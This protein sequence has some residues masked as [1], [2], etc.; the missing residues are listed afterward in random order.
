MNVLDL[1]YAALMALRNAAYDRGLFSSYRSALPV[2][3]VGN[4]SVGGNGKTPLVLYLAGYLKK[5]GKGPVILSRGYG[6][7]CL[8]PQLVTVRDSAMNVGDEPWMMYRK[9]ICPVVIARQRAAGAS[10]I[11]ENRIGETILLDD[12]FQ[13][14]ALRRNLD[15]VCAYAGST[16]AIARF[17]CDRLLPF[18]RLREQKGPA[19]ERAQAIMFT[20]R[21][22]KRISAEVLRDLTRD[23]PRHLKVFSSYLN[24]QRI[25]NS[26]GK[27]LSST[28]TTQVDAFCALAQPEAFFTSIEELGFQIVNRHAF[29]DHAP[30][31]SARL[32]KMLNDSAK[33]PLICTEKDAVKFDPAQYPNVFVVKTSL[34]IDQEAEFQNL[35]SSTLNT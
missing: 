29:S 8:G 6:G 18:G 11:S 4:L 10:F 14:R 35:I 20:S 32:Q 27:I 2:I 23:I 1:P 12:G 13:H 16:Q 33:R 19:L 25:A 3:C 5:A 15:I 17:K 28:D 34:G 22:T 7:R 26:S 24:V 21:S 31:S 9:E 30:V